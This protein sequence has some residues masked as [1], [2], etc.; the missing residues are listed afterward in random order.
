MSRNNKIIELN[1]RFYHF[2]SIINDTLQFFNNIVLAGGS[3]RCIFDKTTV[4]DY[5][6]FPLNVPE[7]KREQYINKLEKHFHFY[8]FKTVFKCPEHKLLSVKHRGIKIQVVLNDE[9]ETVEELLNSFDFT[10]TQFAWH[11]NRFYTTRQSIKD[12]K[13]KSLRL[14]CDDV[15]YPVAS[16]NRIHKYLNRGY[17]GGYNENNIVVLLSERILRLTPDEIAKNSM[18]VYID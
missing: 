7:N 10:V 9:I 15:P 18:R 1:T 8:N 16:L 3:L 4:D 5:D 12:A 6:L 11:N 13:N 14:V 2:P 17:R